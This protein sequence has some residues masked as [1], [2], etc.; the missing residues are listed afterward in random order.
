M[1]D[2]PTGLQEYGWLTS[3]GEVVMIEVEVEVVMPGVYKKGNHD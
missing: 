2:R 3:G 1:V